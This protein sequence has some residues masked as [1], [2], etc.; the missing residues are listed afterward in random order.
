MPPSFD[1]LRMENESLLNEKLDKLE[2]KL[3]AYEI[4]VIT[5]P[6]ADD[7]R[8]GNTVGAGAT[9]FV[10]RLILLAPLEPTALNLISTFHL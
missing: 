10:V 4:T 5:A 2:C 1:T 7:T 6:P 3:N 9:N 8:E